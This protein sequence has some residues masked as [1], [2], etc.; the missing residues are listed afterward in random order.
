MEETS[1][2][3]GLVAYS[4]EVVNGGEGRK[5]E[6]TGGD[7]REGWEGVRGA[8]EVL[9]VLLVEENQQEQLRWRW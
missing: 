6:V 2:E 9:L 3:A 4:C 7:R 1:C 8:R 5:V